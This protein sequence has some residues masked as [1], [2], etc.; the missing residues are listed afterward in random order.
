MTQIQCPLCGCRRFY[1]KDTE[2]EFEIYEFTCENGQIVFDETNEE[3]PPDVT[4]DTHIF[5]DK[6][7]WNG[8]LNTSERK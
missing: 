6:C 3:P 8:A 2:D 7:A 4:D 5:C 1:V